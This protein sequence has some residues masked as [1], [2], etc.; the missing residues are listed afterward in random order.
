MSAT[1]GSSCRASTPVLPSC[2]SACTARLH[3][4]SCLALPVLAM[5]CIWGR[6]WG[7]SHGL[8][9]HGTVAEWWGR[10]GPG[11]GAGKQHV[12]PGCHAEDWVLSLLRVQIRYL[13]SRNQLLIHLSPPICLSVCPSLPAPSHS[14]RVA[15][16]G[17]S[18]AWKVW[19]ALQGC[20]VRKAKAGACYAEHGA[21]MLG[22]QVLT[23]L[24]L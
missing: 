22:K 6:P 19:V 7:S 4:R 2:L 3:L 14:S 21:G 11:S 24:H 16:V 12:F 1:H 8:L 9:P 20:K 13:L 17:K 10:T 5:K 18:S 15:S 23:Q